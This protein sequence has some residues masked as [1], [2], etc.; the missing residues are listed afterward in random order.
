MIKFKSALVLS[1]GLHSLLFAL[2]LMVPKPEGGGEITYYVDLINLPGGGPAGGGPGGNGSGE[3]TENDPGQSLQSP[4]AGSVED[5]VVPQEPEPETG[6]R[7]PDPEKKTPPKPKIQKE[8]QRESVVVRRR[9]SADQSGAQ[10]TRRTAGGGIRSGLGTGPG[11]GTGAGSGSGSG[12]FGNFPYA[13][14]VARMR[15]MIARAWYSPDDRGSGKALKTV[16]YFKIHQNGDI[17][18][19][20]VE[21][22]SGSSLFDLNGLRAVQRA[23]PF[24]PLP[25]DY[26][27]RYLIVHFEFVRRNP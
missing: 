1:M 5:L 27:D 13:Y 23:A 18:D 9:P 8:R 14:Y 6:L 11:S 16:V 3:G 19:L 20:M 4:E 12:G 17:T 7:Y 25:R 24:P 21:E 15:D 10:V 26:P 22:E 2:M